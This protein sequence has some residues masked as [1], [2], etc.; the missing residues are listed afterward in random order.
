[1]FAAQMGPDGY[2][3]THLA[4][5]VLSSMTNQAAPWK[6]LGLYKSRPKKLQSQKPVQGDIRNLQQW[7]LVSKLTTVES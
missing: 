6:S 1:M 7:K 5:C 4:F 2:D 3:R